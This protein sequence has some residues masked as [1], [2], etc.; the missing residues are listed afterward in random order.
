MVDVWPFLIFLTSFDASR[1]A[2]TL[3]DA[4]SAAAQ[5]YSIELSRP[6]ML[7]LE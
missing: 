5:A 7:A 1:T 2:I 6:R 4:S 3:L